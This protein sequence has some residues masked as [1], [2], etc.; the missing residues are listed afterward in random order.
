MLGLRAGVLLSSVLWSGPS[1]AWDV[2]GFMFRFS[3]KAFERQKRHGPHT[4]AT[5]LAFGVQGDG[6]V[7]AKPWTLYLVEFYLAFSCGGKNENPG[8]DLK[9][10]V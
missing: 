4:T 2:G 10:R 5:R 7:G 9:V 8:W 3:C 1:S 6:D